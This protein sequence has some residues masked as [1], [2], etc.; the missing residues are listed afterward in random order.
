MPAPIRRRRC[1]AFTWYR[2]I[3]S[4][5]EAARTGRRSLPVNR[6]D[7]MRLTLLTARRANGF[8]NSKNDWDGESSLWQYQTTLVGGR[9]LWELDVGK[10]RL[11][12][13]DTHGNLPMVRVSLETW[14]G[15]RSERED[16]NM[17]E[18]LQRNQLIFKSSDIFISLLA[19][20]LAVIF[21]VTYDITL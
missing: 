12:L 15:L 7:W 17:R 8:R 4:A 19:G 6:S 14:L 9:L 1:R 21:F 20:Q 18:L 11:S 2:V 5:S 16:R 13:Q 3:A 10:Q